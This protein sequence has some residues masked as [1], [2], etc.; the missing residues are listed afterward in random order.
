[1]K[2]LVK[3]LSIKGILYSFLMSFTGLAVIHM[4][5]YPIVEFVGSLP[6]LLFLFFFIMSNLFILFIQSNNRII[7]NAKI[8]SAIKSPLLWIMPIVIC[9]RELYAAFFLSPTGNYYDTPTYLSAGEKLLGGQL[10]SFRTPVYPL[11]LQLVKFLGGEARLLENVILVQKVISTIAIVLFFYC[12][13]MITKNKA[14]PVIFTVIF[15]LNFYTFSWDY[16]MLTES[17]AISGGI[18]FIYLILKYLHRPSMARAIVTSLLSF[19]LMMFR[20]SFLILMVIV[21]VFWALRLLFSTIDRKAALSGLLAMILCFG[22]VQGYS[23]LNHVQNDYKGISTVTTNINNLHLLINGNIFENPA[24]PE[25]SAYV[26]KVKNGEALVKDVSDEF[27][28]STVKLYVEDTIALHSKEWIEQAITRITRTLPQKINKNYVKA[29]LNEMNQIQKDRL[30]SVKTAYNDM[31]YGFNYLLCYILAFTALIYVLYKWMRTKKIQWIV[32]GI[33]SFIISHLF[34]SAYGSMA[35]FSRLAVPIIPF[36]FCLLAY[37]AHLLVEAV[38][39]Y[40]VYK[41][42]KAM[43]AP[44]LTDKKAK[45]EEP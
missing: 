43:T 14:I 35:E 40:T 17:L 3:H 13:C 9:I 31:L 34:V 21:L 1:M 11:F 7:Q 28:L 2:N 8:Q 32:L 23:Y 16:C 37:Y 6:L 22:M 27:G 5:V 24:Y 4:P 20:P 42:Q 30:T 19:L 33:T 18:L 45:K 29:P 15:A 38:N 44:V 12:L 26:K 25:I 41:Q 36:L 10:D 39:K